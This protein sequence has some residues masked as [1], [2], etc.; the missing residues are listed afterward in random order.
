MVLD[1]FFFFFCSQSRSSRS[2][3]ESQSQLYKRSYPLSVG[4]PWSPDAGI[5]VPCHTVNSPDSY[6]HKSS[7]HEK[8]L[9][10]RDYSSEVQIDS[11]NY[12]EKGSAVV[13]GDNCRKG[14]KETYSKKRMEG[15]SLL[16]VEDRFSVR[17]PEG[18]AGQD[19][20]TKDQWSFT[21]LQN[22]TDEA[23]EKCK[24]FRSFKC[25][26]SSRFSR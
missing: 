25:C 6:L 22:V 7:R 18:S 8:L 14:E 24:R 15:M 23:T 10:Q 4:K 3:S 5:V 9:L 11:R 21:P 26:K 17:S 1:S 16:D 19:Q 13:G 2:R 20:P 12:N